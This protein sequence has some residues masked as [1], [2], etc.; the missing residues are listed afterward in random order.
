[1][2]EGLAANKTP[3]PHDWQEIEAD[4][5]VRGTAILLKPMGRAWIC[6]RCRH[7]ALLEVDKWN[8]YYPDLFPCV[9]QP[10]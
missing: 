4:I 8:P 7:W 5:V 3:D 2:K 6:R 10:R 9:E 1:V